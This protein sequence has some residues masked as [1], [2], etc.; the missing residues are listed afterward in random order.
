MLAFFASDYGLD[1]LG[2]HW[3]AICVEGD[4]SAYGD[5]CSRLSE[6]IDGREIDF[7]PTEARRA[8]LRP[9]EHGSAI[10]STL[11]EQIA[12]SQ[13]KIVNFHRFRD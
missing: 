6:G 3:H 4:L 8:V 1:D 11:H 13:S 9:P 7:A 5:D 10:V 2:A 12:K